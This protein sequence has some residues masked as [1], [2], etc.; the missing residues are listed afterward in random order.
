MKCLVNLFSDAQLNFQE[1]HHAKNYSCSVAEVAK[2]WR[3]KK[4]GFHVE[5]LNPK[6]FSCPYHKH[7]E[8]EELF[9]ILKGEGTVRQDDE[10]YT[11]KEGDLV[12]FKTG[13]AHQFYNHTDSP[14]LFFALSNQSHNEICT[15]PDSNKSLKKEEENRVITQNGIEIDDY[16]RDEEDPSVKW[17]K[18]IFQD[19]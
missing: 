12:L 6:S 14:M 17:P 3:T 16:W 13:V 2:L 5:I 11:V 9:I 15:Y 18:Q 7:Q 4:L 10:F 19:E 1:W 8:E